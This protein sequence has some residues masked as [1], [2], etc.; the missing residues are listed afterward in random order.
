MNHPEWDE[1]QVEDEVD[2]L[3]KEREAATAAAPTEF[4][5]PP[6]NPETKPDEE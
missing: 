1:T 6:E 5:T 4:D 3:A 2:R